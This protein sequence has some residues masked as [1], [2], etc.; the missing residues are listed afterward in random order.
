[1]LISY[2]SKQMTETSTQEC[3]KKEVK[4]ILSSSEKFI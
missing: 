3:A 4:G 1:M 2:D